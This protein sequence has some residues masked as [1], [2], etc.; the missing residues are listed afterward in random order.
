MSISKYIKIAYHNP[1]FR[2]TLLAHI[3]SEL[4]EAGEI[5]SFERFSG[6]R[7]L[8]NP[9]GSC[10]NPHVRGKPRP[11][12][13]ECYQ[14]HNNY[15]A[16][17][18]GENNSHQ[19]AEYMK[20]YRKKF[21]QKSK[22]TVK[23]P[24][25]GESKNRTVRKPV[26]SI[27]RKVVPKPW[28]NKKYR[29]AS[30]DLVKIAKDFPEYREEILDLFF[31]KEARAG[32]K[33][34]KRP[35]CDEVWVSRKELSKQDRIVMEKERRKRRQKGD[36]TDPS[37]TC[38]RRFNDYGTANSQDM[39]AYMKKYRAEGRIKYDPDTGKEEMTS[40]P[41]SSG[42][43]RTE[44]GKPDWAGKSKGE[45]NPKKPKRNKSK[46]PSQSQS[47]PQS[48]PQSSSSPSSSPSSSSPSRSV[49]KSTPEDLAIRDK[50]RSRTKRKV[51]RPRM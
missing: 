16:G 4:A 40:Q 17:S 7:N 21:L 38:N 3:M 19:R 45:A 12:D 20:N 47:K 15:G 39:S 14:V 30:L 18:S 27:E 37:G 2:D 10:S 46:Q 49:S 41:S 29:R 34:S 25:S 11:G 13:G 51:R 32:F 48:Q 42:E 6:A 23:D 43:G 22:E 33:P 35:R 9:R 44:E 1:E 28:G 26:K 8:S 36:K 24:V 31:L 50:I 5:E